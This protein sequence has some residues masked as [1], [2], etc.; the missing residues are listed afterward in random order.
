[1]AADTKLPRSLQLVGL[2]AVLV[3]SISAVN[4]YA[5]VRA[6]VAQWHLIAPMP[7]TW[8]N[9]YSIYSLPALY[10]LLA[11]VSAA[12]FF[13]L[14]LAPRTSLVKA[15]LVYLTLLFLALVWRICIHIPPSDWFGFR[16]A[17]T[18]LRIY[19]G[20]HVFYAI[21]LI[22]LAYSVLPNYSFNRTAAGRSQ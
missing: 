2:T 1:M 10:S 5:H 12:A 17:S 11:V 21:Y 13:T 20:V 4:A 22:G 14:W 6:I 3:F 18:A 16:A 19:L 7:E 9:F 8:D 15:S